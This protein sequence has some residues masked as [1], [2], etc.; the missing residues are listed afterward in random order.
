[1]IDTIFDERLK[2]VQFFYLLFTI[3]VEVT[4]KVLG[5]LSYLYGSSFYYLKIAPDHRSPDPILLG[6]LARL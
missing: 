1:M 4:R 5:L 6:R 2:I 3:N